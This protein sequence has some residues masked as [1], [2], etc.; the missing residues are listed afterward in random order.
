MTSG[1]SA[2]TIA[3]VAGFATTIDVGSLWRAATV[4]CGVGTGLA[5]VAGLL[6]TTCGAGGASVG[7]WT[8]WGRPAATANGSE[9]GLLGAE[10]GAAGFVAT[11]LGATATCGRTTSGAGSGASSATSSA[12]TGSLDGTMIKGAGAT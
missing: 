10:V 5:V 9:T 2:I 4:G 6:A 7:C 3:G 1:A 11:G 8:V 12:R